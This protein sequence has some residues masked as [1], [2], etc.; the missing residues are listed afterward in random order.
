MGLQGVHIEAETV[1]NSPKCPQMSRNI[2]H[3]SVRV[4]LAS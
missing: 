1:S 3:K 2:G 4:R